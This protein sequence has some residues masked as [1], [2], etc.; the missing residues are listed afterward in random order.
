MIQ[1]RTEALIVIGASEGPDTLEHR[2]AKTKRVF[3]K[4]DFG[5]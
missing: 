5:A 4:T 2:V 1:I 3:S